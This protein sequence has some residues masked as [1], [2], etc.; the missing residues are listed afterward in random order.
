M[1]RIDGY[2]SKN[3][4]RLWLENYESLAVGDRF[5][6]APPSFTGPITQDGKGDGRLNKIVLDQAIKHLPK[7][8]RYIVLA[9]YV[10]KIPRKNTLRTMNITETVYYTRCKQAVD[11]IHM[12]INGDMVGMKKLIKKLYGA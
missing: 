9:R 2:V 1:T 10:V 5:P 8:M 4:I 7:N 11:M 12:N 6:D 3:T